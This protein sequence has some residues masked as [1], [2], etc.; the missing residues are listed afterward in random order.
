MSPSNSHGALFKQRWNG[1]WL[2]HPLPAIVSA[3]PSDEDVAKRAYERFLGRGSVHGLDRE[4]WAEATQALIAER[5]ARGPSLSSR[6]EG[7]AREESS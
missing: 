7:S 2:A 4:D 6:E 5:V 3:A 1:P